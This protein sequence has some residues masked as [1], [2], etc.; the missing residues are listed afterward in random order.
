[1]NSWTDT[2]K[3]HQQHRHTTRARTREA[4]ELATKIG[5]GLTPF[6]DREALLYSLT[7]AISREERSSR[8]GDSL[9]KKR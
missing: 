3:A 6:L 2:N 7:Y 4:Q 9:D 8:G 1:M 5:K